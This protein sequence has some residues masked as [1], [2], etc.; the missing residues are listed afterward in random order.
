M[1]EFWQ[2]LVLL[3]IMAYDNQEAGILMPVQN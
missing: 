1:N 2:M 3:M